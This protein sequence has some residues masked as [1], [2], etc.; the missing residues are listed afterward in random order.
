MVQSGEIGKLV[1]LEATCSNL[2]DWG[3][4]WFDM[5]LF[6]NDNAPVEWVFG[7]IEPRGG[8]LLFGAPLESQGI[9]HFKFAND[10]HGLL[11]TGYQAGWGAQNRL[12]GTDGVIEVGVSVGEG[13]QREQRTLRVLGKSASGW[14][15]IPVDE[16]L[17]GS[18]L[19]PRAIRD[20]IEAL[21]TGREPELSARRAL[22]ATELI[23]A[24]YESSRRRG[25]VI[26]PLDVEDSAL[27]ALM[28]E[29]GLTYA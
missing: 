15:D 2:Y 26:L 17:H 4:H 23:F 27:Q 9:S 18:E 11:V 7:Q 5:L 16:G 12:V 6:Y 20:A 3:T 24:T 29:M 1:R 10:V 13:E 19:I 22:Q 8:K 21:Q 25:R 28:N 14:Q